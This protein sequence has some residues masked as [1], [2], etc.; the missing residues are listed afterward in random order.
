MA[1][2]K[3]RFLFFNGGIVPYDDA[4]VHV[5][6]TAFKYAAVVFEGIRAYHDESS[7]RLF[8]FRLREHLDRLVHSTA[9]SRIPLTFSP[10][11]LTEALVGLIRAN[12]L[13]QDLHIRISAYV[14]EDDGRLDS[15]GEPGLSIAAIPMGRY[16]PLGAGQGLSVGVSSWRRIGDDAMPPRVKATGNYTNSRLALLDARAA[17]FQDAILLDQRGKVTEGP[18]YNLFLVRNGTVLTPP[19]TAGIL[20]GVTRDT[21]IRLFADLHGMTVVER[22]IDRTELYVASE[23]FFCGSGKEVTPIGSVDHRRIADGAPG[24]WTTLIR[25]TYFD[26]AKGRRQGYAD[27]LTPVY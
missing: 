19:V 4:R 2:A 1:G 15:V 18:G 7:D 13:R 23:A 11:E 6:S 24:Q 8:I 26:V 25:E 5:L 27:W 21:L 14:A 12:G 20:E 9:I 16:E 22:D 3:P 10:E 17:G